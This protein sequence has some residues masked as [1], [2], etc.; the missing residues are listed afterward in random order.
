M[1][2]IITRGDEEKLAARQLNSTIQSRIN[3][4][5]RDLIKPKTPVIGCDRSKKFPAAVGRVTVEDDR[6]PIAERLR[7]SESIRG[8]R[9]CRAFKHAN[10][11][12]T[13]SAG[14]IYFK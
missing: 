9:N 13:L 2:C 7:Q 12:E 3:S 5:A 4:F 10:R 11:M 14:A 8:S 1:H 6:F